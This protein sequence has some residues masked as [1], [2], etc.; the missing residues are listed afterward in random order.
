MA[1]Q[2]FRPGQKVPLSAQFKVIGPRGA[3][4]N[5]EIT[6]VKGEV[7]PPTTKPGQRYEVA[8]PTKNKSGRK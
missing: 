5:K 6:S 8:D 7:F 2:Q 4:L 1:K 3:D